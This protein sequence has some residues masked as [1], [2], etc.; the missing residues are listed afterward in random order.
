MSWFSCFYRARLNYHLGK[1]TRRYL[2]QLA[3]ASCAAANNVAYR[4]YS[5]CLPDYLSALAAAGHR[6][7]QRDLAR[8]T[9]PEDVH[10]RAAWARE[11]FWRLIGDRP[12]STPLNARTTGVLERDGYR[13]EKVA[14]ESRPGYFVPANLYVPATGKPPYPAVLFQMGHSGNGKAYAS[15]QTCCIGLAKLGFLVLGFDPMGQGERVNY[16][17]A[18]VPDDEHTRPAFQAALIGDTATLWQTWDSIRSLDYLA[19]HPLADPTRLAST[20][21]SGGGTTSMFLACADPRLAAAVIGS[22]NTENFACE[23]FIPPGSTDDG[24]Q[25]LINSIPAGFDRWDL[26]HAF[27]PKPLLVLASA[28]DFFGTYSPNYLANGRQEF[29]LLRGLY[30]KL[31]RAGDIGWYET[32]LPHGLAYDYRMQIYNWLGR[33]LL[34]GFQPVQEEPA[35]TPEPD[36]NVWVTPNNSVVKDLHSATP[37]AILSRRPV[38]RETKPLSA[39]LKV[40]RPASTL[41]ART[42]A[43][44]RFRGVD[45]EAIEVPS[46]PSVWLPAWYFHPRGTP[47]EAPILVAAGNSVRRQWRE[48]GLWDS[49]ASQGISACVADVR[50]TGDLTPDFGRGNPPYSASHHNMNNYAW[51]SLVLGKPLVGQRV[52]DLLALVAAVRNH[53]AAGGRRIALAA[54]GPLVV[55]ALFAAALE[56][57]IEALY[58]GGGLLSFRNLMDTERYSG[59]RYGHNPNPEANNAINVAFGLLQSTDLPEVAAS[60]APRKIRLAGPIDAKGSPV[61]RQTTQRVY[62]NATNLEFHP[63]AAWTPEILGAW[64]RS[65]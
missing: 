26:L 24:E 15:Y 27:A 49:L 54:Q 14:Y 12:E 47:A 34:P 39:I 19:A 16:G 11:T 31:G 13:L 18:D 25:N 1:M 62:A 4:E 55:P 7:R 29:A 38:R 63:A 44:T 65:L 46:A 23:D 59:G 51:A 37:F 36:R 41:Q 48:G 56:P 35:A 22:G 17:G 28:H 45:I 40:D 21:Q 32:P 57:A 33:Y 43:G 3:A 2:L 42:L 9:T 58:L 10:R 8:I 5:R 60:I 53:P 52:T 64:L 30:E 6:R 61:D 20:G 50:G